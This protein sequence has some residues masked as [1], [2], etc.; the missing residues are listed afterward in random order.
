MLRKHDFKLNKYFYCEYEQDSVR[1]MKG[2]IN[3]AVPVFYYN[4]KVGGRGGFYGI[5]PG[6]RGTVTAVDIL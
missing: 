1:E 2:E 6:L 3:P 4:P 5:K